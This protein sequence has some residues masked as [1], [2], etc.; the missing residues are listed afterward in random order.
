MNITQSLFV[1][2][3]MSFQKL[4]SFEQ[5]A[6]DNYVSVSTVKKIFDSIDCKAPSTLSL[7]IHLDEFKG[8]TDEGKMNLCIVDGLSSSVID[9][10]PKRTR[11][12]IEE[13]FLHFSTNELDS[14]RFFVCD[15]YKPY[16]GFAK[17]MLRNSIICI[18]RFHYERHVANAMQAV[19]IRLT[20]DCKD[21][22]LI[23]MRLISLSFLCKYL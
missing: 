4:I 10:L 1:R 2:I 3:Y 8:D 13:Y 16:I 15:M 21:K 23:F 12:V 22:S 5:I 17:E 18:D 11:S 14:V 7:V 20:N 9:I 19:R 6:L